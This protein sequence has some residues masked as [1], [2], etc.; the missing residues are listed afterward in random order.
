MVVYG[1]V[2]I[3]KMVEYAYFQYHLLY[4]KNLGGVYV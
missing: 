1:L 4:I 3:K 2:D